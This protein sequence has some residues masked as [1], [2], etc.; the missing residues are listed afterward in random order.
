MACGPVLPENDLPPRPSVLPH[1]ADPTRF[2]FW[3]RRDGISPRGPGA[4]PGGR[5]RGLLGNCRRD[6]DKGGSGNHE[7]GGGDGEIEETVLLEDATETLT[8][9]P[10]PSPYWHAVLSPSVES[11][12]DTKS[13][14]TR[15][16]RSVLSTP[17]CRLHCSALSRLVV[18]S[19]DDSSTRIRLV[20]SA[21][22]Y[23]S[24]RWLVRSDPLRLVVASTAPSRCPLRSAPSHCPLRSVSLVTHLLCFVSSSRLLVVCSSFLLRLVVDVN[25]I[26][27]S[28]AHCLNLP[29]SLL[30]SNSNTEAN[31][32][33]AV[34]ATP[35]SAQQQDCKKEEEEEYLSSLH[36]GA[37][38]EPE[39]KP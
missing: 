15:P 13:G 25:I 18:D 39:L 1:F 35:P 14:M 36:H 8:K 26:V 5:G 17:S 28:V 6:I 38:E 19:A 22:I 16:L 24:H 21:P 2:F 29:P 9:H 12:V 7:G 30:S 20:R 10:P 31:T 23:P 34:N 37:D 11:S 33:K 3:L 32:V 4:N 27:N